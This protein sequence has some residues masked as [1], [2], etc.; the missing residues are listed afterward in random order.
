MWYSYFSQ[1]QKKY[2]VRVSTKNPLVIRLDGKNATKT[3]K[4]DFINNYEGSFINIM[5]K[6]AKCFSQKYHCYAFFGSDEISFIFP[7]PSNV[8]ND[9][10]KEHCNYS[11][12]ISTLF[13][14]YYFDYFSAKYKVEKIFWHAKCFTINTD[15]IKSY[16]K[17][18]SR[19]ISNVL[20]TFYLIKNQS[21]HGENDTLKQ[22]LL[23][24]KK[25]SDFYTLKNVLDG[26][27]YYDGKR[28]ELNS[29]Y[30]GKNIEQKL[31]E[32]EKMETI[33]LLDF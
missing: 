5:E 16:I 32:I 26:I 7:N 20:T 14:Q 21:Y 8:I 27:L 6:C 17:Y 9:L 30:D 24:C 25:Q 10:D 2:S 1:I 12:E 22:R 13:S 3:R 23:K 19:I 29:F 15:E 18:R 31:P 28:I 33:D 11:Q 4:N